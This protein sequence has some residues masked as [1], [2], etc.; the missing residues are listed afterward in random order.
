[1]EAKYALSKVVCMG[2]E[3]AAGVQ[4]RPRSAGGGEGQPGAGKGR[5]SAGKASKTTW[6]SV[7]GQGADRSQTDDT[8]RSGG[9]ARGVL[10]SSSCTRRGLLV[11]RFGGGDADRGTGALTDVTVT[12]AE[13]QA[14]LQH[15]HFSS[16]SAFQSP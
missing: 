6:E 3:D 13:T 2:G 1:M 10:H 8:G 9:Q 16:P 5:V 15:Q 4:M 12:E 14:T 7:S 11:R